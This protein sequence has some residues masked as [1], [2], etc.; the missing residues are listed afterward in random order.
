MPPLA[1]PTR[2]DALTGIRI[3]A[4]AGVFLSHLVPPLTMSLSV[5]MFMYS[6]YNGV[7]LFFTLSG[8]VLAWN[9]V[10]RL[11]PLRGRQVWS[12][13][14]SRF[15]RIYPLYLF[16]ISWALVPSIMVNHVP[17][18]AWMN[19]LAVATWHPDVAVAYAFNGP[20]WSI[21]VEFF[22]YACFPLVVLALRPIRRAPRALLAVVILCVIVAAGLAWL[23]IVRGHGGLPWDGDSAHRWLYRM[24]LTRLGDFVVG[25]AAA[26]LI[27]CV[28]MRS[29]IATL[30][31]LVGVLTIVGLM[32]QPSLLFTAWSWDA[33]YLGP[34]FLLLWGLAAGQETLL[35]RFL[36]SRPMIVAGEASFAFYILHGPMLGLLTYVGVDTEAKWVLQTILQ[37]TMILIVAVGAHHLIELPAQRWLR[38]TLDRRPRDAEASNVATVE[39]PPREAPQFV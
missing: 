17:S 32:V 25:V 10:D 19:L 5:R 31:Q 28:R 38:R 7:T 9:Y 2:I 6:G 30:A 26:M 3:L 27:R 34:V 8:F 33:V 15:A 12:F 11:T 1:S 14:V 35:A 29:W 18:T 24:P 23:F 21:G 22:L 16:A 37:F 20:A 13:F 39:A 36:A 4:A